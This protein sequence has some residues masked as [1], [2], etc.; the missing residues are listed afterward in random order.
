MFKRGIAVAAIAGLASL[1]PSGSAIAASGQFSGTWKISVDYQ[2]DGSLTYPSTYLVSTNS[3]FNRFTASYS[4]INNDGIFQGETLF[5]P[6]RT[7]KLISILLI[8]TTYY[9]MYVGREVATDRFE[10][11]WYDNAGN[12]GD[13]RFE[14]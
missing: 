12:S 1:L 2:S 5:D 14:R 13:F 10:G 3:H 4:S 9:S 11:T 7:T 8:N 6:A